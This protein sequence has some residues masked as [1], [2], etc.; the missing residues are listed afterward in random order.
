MNGVT[1]YE[2]MGGQ[3]VAGSKMKDDLR[4]LYRIAVFV[5]PERRELLHDGSDRRFVVR[6]QLR[7]FFSGTGGPIR[8]HSAGFK[9]A[10]FDTKRG[11]LL[12]ERLGESPNCPFC[13]MVA[14]AAW[15]R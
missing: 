14:G 15:N 10:D 2:Q 1:A 3:I 5:P 7:C 11:H 9:R 8:P 12:R 13:G 6:K 4:H